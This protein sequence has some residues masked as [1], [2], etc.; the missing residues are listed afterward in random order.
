MA[1]LKKVCNKLQNTSAD[2]MTF[3]PDL[4]VTH[5]SVAICTQLLYPYK[6]NIAKHT[7]RES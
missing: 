3:H 4:K 5:I 7:L 6:P 1:L 2:I